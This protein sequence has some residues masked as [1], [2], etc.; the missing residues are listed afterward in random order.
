MMENIITHTKIFTNVYGKYLV[1]MD[2][3]SMA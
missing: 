3:R 2:K 1:V